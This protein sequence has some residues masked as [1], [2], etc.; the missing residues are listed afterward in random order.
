MSVSLKT[1]KWISTKMK[2]K[3]EIHIRLVNYICNFFIVHILM[4][5]FWRIFHMDIL[6]NASN[7]HI[8]ATLVHTMHPVLMGTPSNKIVW[9]EGRQIQNWE[10]GGGQLPPRTKFRWESQFGPL[11]FFCSIVF[12]LTSLF[13]PS[14]FDKTGTQNAKKGIKKGTLSYNSELNCFHHPYW[15]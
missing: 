8:R 7:F 12:V 13:T 5:Y 9:L 15:W 2:N 6:R 3:N 4:L 14:Y 1:R 10:G 11:G